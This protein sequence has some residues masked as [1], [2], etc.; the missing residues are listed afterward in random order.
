MTAQEA[1]F[2]DGTEGRPRG[3]EYEEENIEDNHE[4]TGC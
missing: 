1:S 4:D 2:R 3:E